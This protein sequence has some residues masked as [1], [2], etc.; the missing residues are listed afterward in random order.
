MDG[1]DE[2]RFADTVTDADEARYEQQRK[3][4][5]KNAY[6]N[7]IRDYEK[8]REIAAKIINA[9]DVKDE[10]A[11]EITQH[12]IT[13]L[14]VDNSHTTIDIEWMQVFDGRRT[15]TGYVETVPAEWFALDDSNLRSVVKSYKKQIQELVEGLKKDLDTAMEAKKAADER[16]A[17]IKRQLSNLEGY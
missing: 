10:E 9:L 4:E 12:N 3:V 2:W 1:M 14:Y 13:A 16:I 11:D 17:E 8:L 6:C 15:A 7:I 5:K